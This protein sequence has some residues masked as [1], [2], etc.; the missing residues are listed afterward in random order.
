MEEEQNTNESLYGEGAVT[1]SAEDAALDTLKDRD[2]EIRD[3]NTEK[4]NVND[5]V[6]EDKKEEDTQTPEDKTETDS[7]ADKKE[8]GEES[9]DEEFTKA[10]Q[11]DH[12]IQEDLKS[13]GV[14]FDAMADE[15]YDNGKLSDE[16]YAALE[17]AGYPK[18]VVDAY[19]KGLE[20]T[21]E[22]FVNTVFEYVGGQE[23]YAKISKY[24]ESQNDGSAERFNALIEKGDVNGIRLALDGFR[25]RMRATSGYTG[26]SILGR[27]AGS[28]NSGANAGYSSKQEM[29]KAMS[30]PRY[31]VDRAYT[32]EVQNKTMNSKFLG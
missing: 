14:D 23:E 7:D 19:V 13:K 12:D 25:A 22:K 17:K 4:V 16:S 11:A 30:D 15:Y 28:G 6:D 31:G 18:S 10:A 21:A 32:M 20:A 29:T 26:R 9:I 2:V 8:D 27:S 5:E 1:G 3:S 24:I